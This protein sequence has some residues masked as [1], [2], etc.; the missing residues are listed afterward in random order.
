MAEAYKSLVLRFG[1]RDEKLMSTLRGITNASRNVNSELRKLKNALKFD[2]SSTGAIERNVKELGDAAAIARAKGTQLRES[3]ENISAQKLKGSSQT[4]GEIASKTRNATMEAALAKERYTNVCGEINKWRIGINQT[5]NSHKKLTGEARVDLFKGMKAGREDIDKVIKKLEEAGISTK[6]VR[7]EAAK[8][9]AAWHKADSR[10]EI[11]KQVEGLESLRNEIMHC[12]ASAE[13]FK[14]QMVEAMLAP[15][16]SRFSSKLKIVDA[17]MDALANASRRFREQLNM[18]PT[19]LNVAAKYVQ[20]LDAQISAATARSRML[21]SRMEQLGRDSSVVR[22]ADNAKLLSASMDATKASLSAVAAKVVDLSGKISVNRDKMKGLEVGSRE[23]EEMRSAIVADEAELRKLNTEM[24]RLKSKHAGQLAAQELRETRTAAA[25]AD[26]AVD[27]LQA[28]FKKLAGTKFPA[29]SLTNVGMSLYSTITPL[30]MMLR[31]YAVQSAN[32]IDAAYRNMR[33]TV[34]GAEEDFERLK[35][36]ALDYGSTHFTSAD[37]IL[38][39]EAIGGMLGIT[40]DNLESFATTVSNL[41]IA[42]N[43]ESEEI[44]EDLGKLATVLGITSDQY[45]HFADSLVRLG[46]SEPAMESDIMKITTRW[47]AMGKIVGMTADEILGW[48]TAATATGQKAEAAG[49]S[50]QRTVAK[51]ETACAN[52]GDKLTIL[53]RTAHMTSDEFK[54]AFEE[55]ASGAMYRLIEGMGEMQNKGE[56]VNQLLTELGWNNVRDKQLVEGFA[57]QM[58]NATDEVNVLKD[59][60]LMSSH[61]WSGVSDQWGDAGDAAREAEKKSQGFSGTLQQLKNVGQ[62]LAASLGESVLPLLQGITDVARVATDAFSALPEPIRMVMLA[63]IVLASAGGPLLTTLGA[64]VPLARDLGSNERLAAASVKQVARAEK[65]EAAALR[66]TAEEAKRT[67][68]SREREA[69]ALN[70][71]ALA[72]KRTAKSEEEL[73]IA[74]AN[75][76]LAV[77]QGTFAR[78]DNAIAGRLMTESNERL[79]AS[80]ARLGAASR[81]STEAARGFAKLAKGLG[82]FI[83]FDAAIAVIAMIGEAIADAVEKAKQF[84]EST[85]GLSEIASTG[86]NLDSMASSFNSV[87]SSAMNTSHMVDLVVE[88]G[89]K[90]AK[91]ITDRNTEAQ[92]HIN[93]LNRAK[94]ILSEYGNSTNHTAG[95]IG[96]F[97]QAVATV[98]ELCGTQYRVVD[99]VAGTIADERG[100][101]VSLNKV[102]D[103]NIE[104]TKNQIRAKALE[105][106]LTEAYTHQADAKQALAQAQREYND[107]QSRYDKAKL[108]DKKWIEQEVAAAERNLEKMVE[109]EKY[110]TLA[111]ESLEK[112]FGAMSNAS[113]KSSTDVVSL[114]R[115]MDTLTTALKGS[116]DEAGTERLEAFM[117]MLGQ[118]GIR[119]KDLKSLSDEDLFDIG[120]NFTSETDVDTLRKKF[121]D[122]GIE[123]GVASAMV[124]KSAD[125]ISDSMGNVATAA[126]EMGEEAED[127]TEDLDLAIEKLVAMSPNLQQ[128]MQAAKVDVQGLSEAMKQAGYDA[129][130]LADGADEMATRVSDGFN[131]IEVDSETSLE[132]YKENLAENR[133]VVEEWGDNLKSLYDRTSDETVHAWLRSLAEAGPEHANIV[134]ELTNS[135]DAE[136]TQMAQDWQNAQVEGPQHYLDAMGAT[137]ERVLGYVNDM[138]GGTTTGLGKLASG[139]STAADG[140]SGI[141][142]AFNNSSTVDTSSMGSDAV[143]GIA[144]GIASGTG[145]V[146]SAANGVADAQG[147]MNVSGSTY[148]WGADAASNLADGIWSKVYAIREA[149]SAGA[150]EISSWW[151]H[152]TPKKGPLKDDDVWGAHMVDNLVSGMDSRRSLLQR[153]SRQLA[154]LAASDFGNGKIEVAWPTSSF[155]S[156]KSGGSVT[157]NNYSIAGVS[158]SEGSDGARALE[159]LYKALRA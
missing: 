143:N 102:I 121:D 82:A 106:D 119:A 73:R 100:E 84:E 83:A 113:T 109:E 120:I 1:A 50:M 7:E 5:Y 103:E 75:E 66:K 159:A 97:R 86:L 147:N 129:Q 107:A 111:A 33:K 105:D 8:L 76:R 122:L 23:Y 3:L 26:V 34:Q 88:S 93:L 28:D 52:G 99:A 134:A 20:S 126:S 125:D 96:Q 9:N 135:S 40:V 156:G 47:G 150:N 133:R 41:D 57:L 146:V 61:A 19:S 58:S 4:I 94:T 153:K 70:E 114:A 44:A 15:Q 112:Q 117:D 36:A 62:E 59:S 80:E 68:A 72:A 60:L 25:Q 131:K 45:D 43:M 137:S 16:P 55:D 144:G 118:L 12:D 128:T 67:A 2:P 69:K 77:E 91:S 95:E 142:G 54:R 89:A 37:T 127:A 157:N 141:W 48:S 115:S 124:K 53:A 158:F 14:N 42:T 101:L 154:Q 27:K 17:D 149:A 10:N 31:T 85:K 51:I 24:D 78:Q 132:A 71:Q 39:I 79:A 87:S 49:S 13:S 46:N 138:V 108:N 65:E 151:R 152:S 56:S 21:H 98:N 116:G 110:A 145:N 155:G 104:K 130:A 63:S 64:L 18:N 38:E 29:S 6:G 35:Q 123:T 11:M 148:R 90:L 74:L 92:N 81:H 139:F 32:D 140:L 22:L 30:T 136:L